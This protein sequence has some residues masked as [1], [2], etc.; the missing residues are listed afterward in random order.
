MKT[1]VAPTTKAA[2]R[3]PVTISAGDVEATIYK[4]PTKVRGTKYDSFTL[5]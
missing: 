4:T 1:Q 5:C 3:F 2:P